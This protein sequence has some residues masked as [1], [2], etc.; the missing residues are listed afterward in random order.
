VS[1]KRPG[2]KEAE[3]HLERAQRAFGAILKVVVG[4]L[5]WALIPRTAQTRRAFTRY[6]R[7]WGR[8]WLP[9]TL[10][11]LPGV[12]LWVLMKLFP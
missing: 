5:G 8:G 6:Y 3:K 11:L 1:V 4:W 7:W 2:R 10:A 9:A 12:V